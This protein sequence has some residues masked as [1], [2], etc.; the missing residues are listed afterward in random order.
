MA[1]STP[2]VNFMLETMPD[3]KRSQLSVLACILDEKVHE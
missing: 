1:L 2:V 3:E